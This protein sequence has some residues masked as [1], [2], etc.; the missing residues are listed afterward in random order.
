[1]ATIFAERPR[2]FE[3]QYLGA[4]DLQ[5]FLN[6]VREQDARHLLGAHTWGIVTGM[7]LVSSTSPGG[8]L[9]YF[10]TPGIAIDGYGRMIVIAAT[11]RLTT[12]LFTSQ[13][14][15]RVSV[16]IRYEEAP[17]SGT[18]PGFQVCD[19]SDSFARVQESFVIETGPRNSVILRESDVVVGDDTFADAREALGFQ[20]TNQPLACDGSVAAQT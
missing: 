12:E 4:D 9:D 3:G 5:S 7:E 18:R 15:G 10:L 16:W 1:M 19:C 6:Y 14:T 2:F 20:L 17:F 8:T 11:Y 13:P